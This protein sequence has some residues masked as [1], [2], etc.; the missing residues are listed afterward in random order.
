MTLWR[1]PHLFEQR[2][3]SLNVNDNVIF[4]TD[5]Y[6]VGHWPQYPPGT[7]KVYSYFESRGGVFADTTFFGLQYILHKY[8]TRV[9][10]RADIEQADSLFN[11]HFGTNRLFNKD[12]WAHISAL[13]YFPVTIKAVPEG[14]T[15]PTRNVLITI[16]NTDPHCY[17]LTNYLETLLVQTWYP[18]TV[19]YSVTG[20]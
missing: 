17:W 4:L 9:P 2:A 12:G 10:S 14:M 19:L 11:I 13:G 5:S 18:I 6:K 15:I 7:T 3:R 20:V 8:L 16:E 1:K